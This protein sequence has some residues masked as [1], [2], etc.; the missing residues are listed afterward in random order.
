MRAIKVICL[1]IVGSIFTFTSSS[2]EVVEAQVK[3]QTTSKNVVV[4]QS[5][6]AY[7]TKFDSL[8]CKIQHD[9]KVLDTIRLSNRKLIKNSQ[10]CLKAN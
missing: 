2:N 8:H 9:L 10:L 1:C 4:K 5:L 7:Q 6:T 3:P